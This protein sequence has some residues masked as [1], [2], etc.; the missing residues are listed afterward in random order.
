MN[1]ALFLLAQIFVLAVIILSVVTADVIRRSRANRKSE[2]SAL[3][4]RQHDAAVAVFAA[5]LREAVLLGRKK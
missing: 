2:A 4:K 5:V 1:I 3:S